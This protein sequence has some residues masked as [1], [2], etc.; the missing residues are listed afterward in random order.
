M[1]KIILGNKG[2][3]LLLITFLSAQCIFA[4]KSTITGKVLDVKGTVIAGATVRLKDAK[5]GVVSND[6]GKF[7]L[8]VSASNNS[9]ITVSY[10]GYD[11]QSLVVTDFTKEIV[12]ILKEAGSTLS[13]VVVTANNS[14]RSQMEMPISVTTFSASKIAS[15]R[16]NSNADILRVVPGITAEGGGGDVASNIFVR[17]LP[18]GGQYQ[19]TP[20]QI[21]G[22][23]VVGTM[24]LNSSAPDVYFR[25]D[26]GFN[27]IEFVCGGS[28]KLFGAG[29]VA[30]SYN[31]SYKFC[32]N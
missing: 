7:I 2:I 23:P 14:R 20:L 30:G 32:F 15:L 5:T 16:F 27:N 4:Q 31:F 28:S 18:S 21:D 24:G 9:T 29:S 1:K 6:E 10:V 3:I 22:M 8:S 19:F 13:S 17:G 25:N 11:D 26:L 12:V